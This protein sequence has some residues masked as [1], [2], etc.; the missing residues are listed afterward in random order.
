M[1]LLIT[2]MYPIVKR[3]TQTVINSPVV[4]FACLI[5]DDIIAQFSYRSKQWVS[6]APSSDV[7]RQELEGAQSLP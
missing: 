7:T 5:F 2:L 1:K 4:H 6:A 3:K